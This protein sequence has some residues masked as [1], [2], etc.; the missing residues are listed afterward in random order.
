M[1]PWTPYSSLE[2]TLSSFSSGQVKLPFSTVC[3]FTLAISGTY[4]CVDLFAC[5]TSAWRL[6]SAMG[7]KR[8]RSA[9]NHLVGNKFDLIAIN[10]RES[11][12]NSITGKFGA[13][14]VILVGKTKSLLLKNKLS[15]EINCRLLLWRCCCYFGEDSFQWGL[16]FLD[17]HTDHFFSLPSKSRGDWDS[18]IYD[19]F[20]DLST[21][22][23]IVHE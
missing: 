23:C 7:E 22:L 15:K 18:L 12:Y 1:L 8:R 6:Q 17:T 16:S 11:F 10:S 19:L 5:R 20:S 13:I 9:I 2:L 14:S 21:P 4:L 3:L